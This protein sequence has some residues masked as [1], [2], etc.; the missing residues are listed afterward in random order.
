[1]STNAVSGSQNM[2]EAPYAGDLDKR[3]TPCSSLV[4]KGCLLVFGIGFAYFM[5]QFDVPGAGLL[6]FMGMIGAAQGVYRIDKLVARHLDPD[7]PYKFPS[8]F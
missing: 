8:F 7:Q 2:R 1:M 4:A 3:E 5:S 6:G